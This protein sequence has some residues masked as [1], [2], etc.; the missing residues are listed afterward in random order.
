[1]ATARD[2][3]TYYEMLWKS[4]QLKQDAD[5]AMQVDLAFRQ[6]VLNKGRYLKVE[7]RTQVPWQF[8][9][10]ITKRETDCSFLKCLHNGDPLNQ[11]TTHVPQGRGPFTC[12]EDGAVDA[13]M[14]KKLHLVT[15]W[16]IP[17]MLELAEKYNGPGYLL[18]HP[19]CNSPYLWSMTNHYTAGKY[20]RDGHFNASLVDKQ[21][22]VAAMFLKFK[23][24]G[25]L[26]GF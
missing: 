3:P 9:A 16:K 12:W 20:D 25:L 24:E 10:A 5:S 15:D 8:V 17:K 2:I 23:N 7:A 1:M 11:V 4:V 14:I 22:G 13:L 18:Y 21:V 26:Q 6:A 19:T